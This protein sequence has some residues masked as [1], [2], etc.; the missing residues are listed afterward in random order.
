MRQH[1]K[2]ALLT[3]LVKVINGRTR[4]SPNSGKGQRS[5]LR[6]GSIE[7]VLK[8][9]KS[10]VK[11]KEGEKVGL[12]SVKN[13]NAQSYAVIH[14]GLISTFGWSYHQEVRLRKY[15]D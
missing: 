9:N 11:S 14:N 2:H 7:E 3:V 6:V 15:S 10:L 5:L 4:K 8:V 1:L 13:V 12:A